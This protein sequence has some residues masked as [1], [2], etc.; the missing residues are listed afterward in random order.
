MTSTPLSAAKLAANR[1][2]A[3]FSSG[4]RTEQGKSRTSGNAL[5]FGLFAMR[6]FVR[7]DEQEDY[8][9]LRQNLLSDLRPAGVLELAHTGEILSATWRLLRCALLEATMALPNEALP[10][11]AI[12]DP[13]ED[14][15]TLKLQASIDRAR[16]QAWNMLR[17]A[18][19]ELE[20]LQARRA[21]KPASSASKPVSTNQTH[22]A[23]AATTEAPTPPD[24]QTPR[25][26]RCPCQSG[27]KYK[28]CCGPNA[29]PILN[30]AA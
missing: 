12:S 20:R 22:P 29:P 11:D 26:A 16:T 8:H 9:I 30:L 2:N 4:P 19:A 24:A 6:D 21:S 13:M 7:P 27:Q 18:T 3:Q 23:T 1:H 28:R 25:N 10:N 5:S 17:R 15:E 14:P